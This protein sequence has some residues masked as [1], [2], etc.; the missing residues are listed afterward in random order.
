MSNKVVMVIL[1]AYPERYPAIV[2]LAKNLHV[3]FDGAYDA[4]GLVRCNA[5]EPEVA[6]LDLRGLTEPIGMLVHAARACLG[7]AR[8]IVIGMPDD[9]HMAEQAIVAGAAGFLS[10][11]LSDN[12][13]LAAIS[14]TAQGALHLTSTGLRAINKLVEENRPK[15]TPRR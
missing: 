4:P 10:K 1:R 2:P 9:E 7:R 5:I 8:L 11:D 14:R 12:A 13:L 15:S 6:L 3:A